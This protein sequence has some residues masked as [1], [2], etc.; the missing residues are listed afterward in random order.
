MQK[1]EEETKV[2]PN[3]L[4]IIVLWQILF[5]FYQNYMLA[6]TRNT[7]SLFLFLFSLFLT[8]IKCQPKACC[9]L[10]IWLRS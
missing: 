4:K 10:E 5:H 1:A 6:T 8:Y 3:H 7:Q 9:A 2:K